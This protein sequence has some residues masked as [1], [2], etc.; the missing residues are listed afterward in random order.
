MGISRRLAS[1]DHG[2]CGVARQYL[3]GFDSLGLQMSDAMDLDKWARV[4]GEGYTHQGQTRSEGRAVSQFLH[5]P[6]LTAVR[7]FRIIPFTRWIR[8]GAASQCSFRL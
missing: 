7:I 5:G 2:P 1:L 4:V 8:S 6:Q 3:D